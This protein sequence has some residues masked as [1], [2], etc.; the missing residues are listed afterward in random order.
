MGGGA[1]GRGEYMG[2]AVARILHCLVLLL[3]TSQ[4]LTTHSLT[5]RTFSSLQSDDGVLGSGATIGAGVRMVG[6]TGAAGLGFKSGLSQMLVGLQMRFDQHP[7]PQEYPACTL[8][9]VSEKERVILLGLRE[10]RETKNNRSN[11]H[12]C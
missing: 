5:H 12:G 3:Q 9:L 2:D 7:L 10:G 11:L 4:S 1:V 6:T 8:E